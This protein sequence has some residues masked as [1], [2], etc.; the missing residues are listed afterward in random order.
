LGVPLAEEVRD[1][2][3]IAKTQNVTPLQCAEGFRFLNQLKNC[4]LKLDQIMPF[5]LEFY[6][7]CVS[8]AKEPREIFSICNEI[9]ELQDPVPL[10][11]LPE[12]ISKLVERKRSLES[13]ISKVEIAIKGLQ[14]EFSE[15]FDKV[16]VTRFDLERYRKV[17]QEL[18]KFDL[19]LQGLQKIN[20]IIEKV[21]SIGS[22]PKYI[23]RELIEIKNCRQERSNLEERVTHLKH[24]AM[25]AQRELRANELKLVLCKELLGQYMVIKELKIGSEELKNLKRIVLTSA[26]SNSLDPEVA[27]RR[28]SDDIL[29]NYDIELGLE[30]KN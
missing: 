17:E 5:I 30:K 24:E 23:A 4:G 16:S 1:L 9:F 13:D 2:C 25:L 28:F 8:A 15:L 21:N 10:A 3:V 11:Q 7:L 14:Q 20:T 18:K 12:F 19:T 29:T 26:E 6:N 27:F 22:D